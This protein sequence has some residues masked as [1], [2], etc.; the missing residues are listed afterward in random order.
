VSRRLLDL[1]PA[2]LLVA[3]LFALGA[4]IGPAQGG[5]VAWLRLPAFVVTLAGL[6]V[7]RGAVYLVTDGRTVAPRAPGYRSLGVG[8][9]A[10]SARC[11]AGRSPPRP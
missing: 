8:V 5:L 1:C 10:R 3:W 4:A 9:G 11:R 2:V 7:F 6:L